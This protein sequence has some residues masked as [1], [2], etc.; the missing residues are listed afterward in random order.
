MADKYTPFTE[1]TKKMGIAIEA[2]F[3]FEFDS[4]SLKTC[5]RCFN[6]H[7]RHVRN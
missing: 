5:L 6:S 4:D 7:F 2:R 1:K 3:I